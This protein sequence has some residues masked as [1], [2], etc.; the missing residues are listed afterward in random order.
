LTLPSRYDFI[1]NANQK[2]DV[3]WIR[4][5]GL[6]D[7]I[8]TRAHGAA[9]L[10]YDNLVTNEEASMVDMGGQ[11]NAYETFTNIQGTVVIKTPPVILCLVVGPFKNQKGPPLNLFRHL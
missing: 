3:Y 5:G 10:I 9:L 8:R 4:F 1:L 2:A 11:D 7:C 6:L